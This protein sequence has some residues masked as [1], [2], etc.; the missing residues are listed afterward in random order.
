MGA[1]KCFPLVEELFS[2][3]MLVEKDGLL[4]IYLR[5]DDGKLTISFDSY[6]SYRKGDEGDLLKV[7]EE[8]DASSRL[9]CTLYEVT[10][11]NYMDW[12]VDQCYGIRSITKIKEYMILTENDVIE[13]ISIDGPI[14]VRS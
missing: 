3:D 4:Q 2:L 14:I 1:I 12:F 13:V 11:S 7:I 8:V 6:L 10:S 5:R 9:G